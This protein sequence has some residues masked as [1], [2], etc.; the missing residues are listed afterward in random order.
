M[1]QW[2]AARLGTVITEPCVDCVQAA[3]GVDVG[4]RPGS[5]DATVGGP[6]GHSHRPSSSRGLN[7][8]LMYVQAAVGVN[9][10]HRPGSDDATAG[11]PAGHSHRPSPSGRS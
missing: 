9:V 6:T 4:N 5:D 8:V 10:G 1:M 11:G 2:L 3:V 7:T